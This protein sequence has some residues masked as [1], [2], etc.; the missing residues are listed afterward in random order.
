MDKM[1]WRCGDTNP[2]VAAVEADAIIEIGDLL[3]HDEG[4]AK[5]A[6]DFGVLFSTDG[7]AVQELL[8]EFAGCF[9][10]VAMQ[11][12]PRGYGAPI[13]VAT[14]GV[15]EFDCAADSFEL[16]DLLGPS[17]AGRQLARQSVAAVNFPRLAI[18]RVARFAKTPT[19]SVLAR[20]RSAVMCGGIA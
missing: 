14:T 10:G 1:R 9:L 15:F 6:E 7:P 4:F 2:V 18:A 5:P 16:G 12:S 11:R 3:F 20:I 19:T 8:E 13:H 17:V